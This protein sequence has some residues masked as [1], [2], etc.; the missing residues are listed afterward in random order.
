MVHPEQSEGAHLLDDL[1]GEAVVV[2]EREA[3]G[4][5]LPGD[6]STDDIDE[7]QSHVI[8]GGGA[9]VRSLHR[10]EVYI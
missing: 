8:A 10:C 9:H 1:G 5:H 7:L 3:T 6:E 2:L 4:D